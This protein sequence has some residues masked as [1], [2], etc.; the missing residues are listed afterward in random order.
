MEDNN[1]QK[2]KVDNE[3]QQLNNK[4]EPPM[5]KKKCLDLT[6]YTWKKDKVQMA[7]IL[8][9][10]SMFNDVH[11]LGDEM[12]VTS[13][14][15]PE[16]SEELMANFRKWGTLMRDKLLALFE[17]T[18]A[19]YQ[20]GLSA[21]HRRLQADL[22]ASAEEMA[23]V[24]QAHP[25][26][27]EQIVSQVC[28]YWKTKQEN[29]KAFLAEVEKKHA[30]GELRMGDY[31]RLITNARNLLPVYSLFVPVLYEAGSCGFQ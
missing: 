23:F 30:N 12:L 3:K 6:V 11:E 2:R 20:A 10:L 9:I 22:Y 28:T 26:T 27:L 14:Y 1:K 4:Q 7:F 25:P 16:P 21:M 17:M 18:E 15:D 29:T 19:D 8:E 24:D 31:L 5:K 13:N